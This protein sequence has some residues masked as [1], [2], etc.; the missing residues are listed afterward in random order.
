MTQQATFEKSFAKNLMQSSQTH[1]NLGQDFIVTTEDK[2]R[3]CM[4]RHA[5]RLSD[6]KAWTTPVSLFVTIVLV[7]LTAGFHDA[8][9][10]TSDT[11]HALFLLSAVATLIWSM[12]AIIK[13][14]RT[15]TSIDKIVD[16]LKLSSNAG[17][18][19]A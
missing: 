9:G 19:Q 17:E 12:V 15:S 16:E 5:H 18:H 7:L 2:V 13:A 1:V 8:F 11:W 10:I 3:L 4:T 6:R 14:L